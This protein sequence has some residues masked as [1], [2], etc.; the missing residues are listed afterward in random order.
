MRAVAIGSSAEHGSSISSTSGCMA[1]ARAMHRRCCWPPDRARALLVQLVL[2]LI[3][4]RRLAQR[5]LD[6]FGQ[7]A[8]IAVHRRPPGDVLE[9][10]LGERVGL[11]EDHADAAAQLDRVP[12]RAVHVLVLRY[13]SRPL[14]RT[15]SMKSFMRFIARSS[16][17][18]PQP[19]GPMIAV[20]CLA[21]MSSVTSR[22]A[23][24]SP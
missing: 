5:F 16:V 4:Q 11:L 20:T 14:T 22:T 10:R 8:A 18:L 12:G 3:P 19:E 1:M 7:V 21:G 13:S 23:V 9:D 2:H 24:K 15:P 6:Q 17:L